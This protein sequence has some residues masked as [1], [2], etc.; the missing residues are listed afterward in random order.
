MN[1]SDTD[2]R[3]DAELLAH[4]I[5]ESARP[6]LVELINAVL[7]SGG[8]PILPAQTVALETKLIDGKDKLSTA[9]AA[10]L[11]DCS[12]SHIRNLVDKARNKTTTV[13]IPFQDLDG[14]LRFPRTQLIEWRDKPKPRTTRAGKHKT[15]LAAVRS[16]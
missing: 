13:P 12:E 15:Q 16:Q 4:K 10:V 7:V 9:E 14:I 11:L 2:K 6:H 8:G 1:Q 3:A 5:L